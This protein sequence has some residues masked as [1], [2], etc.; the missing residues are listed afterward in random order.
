MLLVIL[1]LVHFHI[2]ARIKQEISGISTSDPRAGGSFTL[3]GKSYSNY[4]NFFNINVWGTDKIMRG[5]RYAVN[6]GWNS[7]YLGIYGGSKFIYN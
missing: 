2:A 7:P 4:Y 6:N 1:V 3:D 5:M